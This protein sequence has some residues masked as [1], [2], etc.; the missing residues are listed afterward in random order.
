[1][2]LPRRQAS[3]LRE[4]MSQSTQGITVPMY[5]RFKCSRAASPASALNVDPNLERNILMTDALTLEAIRRGIPTPAR[6]TADR[7]G[8]PT[9]ARQTGAH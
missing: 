1:M 5:R 7:L 8:I 4:D 9:P 6:Q 2:T 3:G